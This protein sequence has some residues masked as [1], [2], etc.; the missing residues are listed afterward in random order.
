[1]FGATQLRRGAAAIAVL[2]FAA[3]AS[4]AP[5]QT[6]APERDR[7]AILAM[8]G[9]YR[10]GFHFRETTALRAG[11]TL[12][13]PYE[14]SATEFVT[15]IEDA[16]EQIVLQHVLVLGRAEADDDHAEATTAP[17]TQPSARVVK[18]WRQAWRFEPEWTWEYA[19]HN[20]WRHRALTDNE[21]AGQWVQ[22]V[23]Q[24]DD[25]PRYAS[26]GRWTHASGAGAESVIG[27]A[28]EGE[29]AWRPLPR[30]EWLKR[31][32]YHVIVGRNRH[33]LT[34]TG[35]VH[36]Q[37]NAKVV[38][39]ASGKPVETF[40]RE[41]GHNVYDRRGEGTATA[42]QIDFAPGYAYWRQTAP[43]WA[44]VRAAWTKRLASDGEV[45]LAKRVDDKPM[46]A[47]LFTYAKQISEANPYDPATGRAYIDRTLAAFGAT[48]K[49]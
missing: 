24:V 34:P 27:S 21:R 44:D 33:T 46:F 35:W 42:M 1:M 26:L 36:E 2:F 14:T 48:P 15:V 28:W 30:R 7:Q 3:A 49:P 38:L 45:R 9:E 23:Y 6:P 8:A 43:F 29:P 40:V 20:T 37:D 32:N 5:A 4:P 10:V 19:G 47:H 25:S 41:W 11:Y 13:K 39:D 18:H 16:P 31:S 22:E 17:A 12:T